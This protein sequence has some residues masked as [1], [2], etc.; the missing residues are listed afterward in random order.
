MPSKCFIVVANG[1]LVFFFV[2]VELGFGHSVVPHAAFKH[3]AVC[4]E[5]LTVSS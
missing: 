5:V 4:I 1:S 2:C 3:P